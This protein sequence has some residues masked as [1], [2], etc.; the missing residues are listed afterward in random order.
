MIAELGGLEGLQREAHRTFVRTLAHRVTQALDKMAGPRRLSPAER[1]IQQLCRERFA[2]YDPTCMNQ[3][4]FIDDL[5]RWADATRTTQAE[6]NRANDDELLSALLQES[7]VDKYPSRPPERRN[8]SGESSRR[9][10][11]YG[12]RRE[13]DGYLGKWR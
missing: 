3:V 1:D 4:K 10:P 7:R 11:Q 5:S 12:R 13:W 6:P 2:L 8:R 9:R